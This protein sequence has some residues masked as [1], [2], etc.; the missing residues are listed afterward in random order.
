MLQQN[1][2][3]PRFPKLKLVE[4]WTKY[5]VKREE[6]RPRVLTIAWKS[7]RQREVRL[8]EPGNQRMLPRDMNR[9]LLMKMED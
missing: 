3:A 4:N 2:I 8:D 9:D 1:F 5:G 6:N 7:K